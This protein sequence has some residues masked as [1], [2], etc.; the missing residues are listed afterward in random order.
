MQDE[1]EPVPRT[2]AGILAAVLMG[3]GMILLA[4]ASLLV[5]WRAASTLLLLGL[6]ALAVAFIL[7]LWNGD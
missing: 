6:I 7:H 2:I 1:F 4:G 5:P 3:V